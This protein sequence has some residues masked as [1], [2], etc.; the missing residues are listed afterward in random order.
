MS[1]GI[2]ERAKRELARKSPHARKARR[3]GERV[4]SP[5]LACDD[6]L[7]RSRFARSTIPEEKW[8]LLVVY[9]FRSHLCDFPIPFHLLNQ[10]SREKMKNKQKTKQKQIHL[11]L[12]SFPY[13]KNNLFALLEYIPRC[14]DYMRENLQGTH[15]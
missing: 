12:S 13:F 5:F 3:G 14:L 15:P 9:Y 6:F 7:S 1:L 10:C 2:E 4:A 8:G 11:K